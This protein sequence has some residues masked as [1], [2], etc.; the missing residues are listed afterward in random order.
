VITREEL[1]GL[2]VREKN[3]RDCDYGRGTDCIVITTEE[4]TGL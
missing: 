4:R 2:C 1:I 3:G